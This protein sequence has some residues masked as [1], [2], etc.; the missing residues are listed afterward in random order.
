MLCMPSA[1]VTMHSAL[2]TISRC[3]YA[4]CT[5]HHQQML[6][7]TLHCTPTADVTMHSA[8]HTNSRCYYA[9]CTAHHQQM[10]LCTLC[11]AHHQQM[12]LCT[13]HC[14]PT[15]DVTMHSLHCTPSAD[16]P[17]LSAL[18]TISTLGPSTV[19][20][21]TPPT[22]NL[23]HLTQFYC[24][25]LGL[26]NVPLPYPLTPCCLTHPWPNSPSPGHCYPVVSLTTHPS[27]Y[28]TGIP[29]PPWGRRQKFSIK[30]V[31]YLSA[32]IMWRHEN[33]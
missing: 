17:M 21:L 8:L 4:L 28:P 16:V 19:L 2:H 18:H 5:A 6:L 27:R 10:L 20:P 29:L 30:L 22:H 9:L 14:T 33:S 1:D 12:L 7:C 31:T 11:T 26:C 25:L 32:D 23:L 3:Y 24:I 15:A 13:L